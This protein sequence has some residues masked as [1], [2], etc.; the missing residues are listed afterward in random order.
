[1]LREFIL[2]LKVM[3]ILKF[4]KW[5]PLELNSILKAYLQVFIYK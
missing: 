2:Q 4:S 1:M 3:I 5:I